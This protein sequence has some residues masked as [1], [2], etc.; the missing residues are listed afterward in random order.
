MRDEMNRT[1]GGGIQE[2]YFTKFVIL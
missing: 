2:V 1:L